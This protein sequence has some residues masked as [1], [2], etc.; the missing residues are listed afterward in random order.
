MPRLSTDGRV[1]ATIN[2][3]PN[4]YEQIKSLAATEH[5]SISQQC[6]YLLSQALATE[7]AGRMPV[8]LTGGRA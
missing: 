2:M 5:R 4:L 8:V 1:T 3:P 7:P 6:A